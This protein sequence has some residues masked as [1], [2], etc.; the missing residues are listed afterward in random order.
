MRKIVLFLVISISFFKGFGQDY[1]NKGKDFWFCYPSHQAGTGSRLAIYLTSEVNASGTVSFGNNTIPFTVAANQTAIVRIGNATVPSN[2]TCY[3]SSNNFVEKNKAIHIQSDNP[4]AAYAHILNA[5]VSGST[6]L[7]PVPVLG[8]EYVVSSY[9]PQGT[10]ANTEKCEFDIV[11]VEDNTTVE[12]TPVNADISGAHPPFVPFQIVINK[13]DVYQYQS[14]GELSGTTVKSIASGTNVCQRI[15][16]IGATTRSAI[17]CNGASSG[18]NLF[19]QLTPKSS[20]GRRY[21]T[22]PFTLKNH[23]IIRIYASVPATPVIVNGVALPLVNIINNSYYEIT[24]STPQDISSD[25]PIAVF[26]YIITQNCDNV[27]SD[28]E[29]IFINPVEQTLKDITFVS[30]HNQLTPPN[31]NI[32]NHYL[33]LILKNSG[34]SISSLTVDGAPPAVTFTPI[35]ATGYSYATINLT[36]TTTLASPSHRVI[37]DSG[38]IA[39]AYGYGNVESYGYNAGTNVKDLTQQLELGTTYGTEN[40]PTLCIGENFQFKAYFPIPN[41]PTNNFDSLRWTCTSTALVP[42]NLPILE[43]GPLGP[44][45]DSTNIRNGKLVNWYSLPGLYSFNAPG[46]YTVTLTVYKSTN[47]G[48]GNEQD[49]D[50]TITVV[51]PPTPSFTYSAP[52]CYLEPVSFT[53]T[54]PQL[55]KPTYAWYWNFGDN[56]TSNQRNPTHTYAAAGTYTVKYVGITTTGCVSDT[57]TQ[58][59]TVPDVPNATISA[60]ATSACINAAVQPQVTF[61]ISGGTAPYLVD[62]SFNGTPQPTINTGLNIITI[63]VSTAVAGVFTYKL[64]S[65]K[66]QGSTLCK[67]VISNQSVT[68]TINPNVVMSYVNTSGAQNQTVC[69]NTPIS[70]IQYTLTT[71]GTGG[72][73]VFTSGTPAGITGSYNAGTQTYTIAGTPAVAGTYPFTV[74]PVATCTDPANVFNGVLT[75]SANATLSLQSASPDRT[76]CVN[77]AI[78]LP[79]DYLTGGGATGA[80]VTFTPALPGVTGTYNAA[81]HVFSISGTPSISGTFSYTVN[82]VSTCVNAPPLSGT[83]TVNA[84]AGINLTSLPATT[85]QTVCVNTPVAGIAYDIIGTV[86]SVTVTGLPAGVTYVYTPGVLPAN[87]SLTINGTPTVSNTIPYTY[88]ITVNGPC[89][90]PTPMNGTILVNPDAGIS[91]NAGSNANP[92]VC[93]NTPVSISYTVTGTV[94]SV[95]VTGTLPPGVTSVYTPG[96]GGGPG[97]LTISGTPTSSAGSPYNYT[98]KVTGPCQTP[99][100]Q[101]GAIT[102]T[103]DA[104]ISL[105]SPQNY[106]N[107][108]LCVNH[109]ILTTIWDIGGSATNAT[110][111]FTPPLPG[112]TGVYNAGT[113]QVT[114]SGTPTAVAST[115]VTYT[116]HV[117]TSGPCAAPD[118]IGSITVYPD[119]TLSIS[120]NGAQTVCIN[121]FITPIVYTWG[122]GA[123]GIVLPL[124][125]PPGL[126][127]TVDN[128]AQTVTITGAPSASGT[129][130]ITTV[131]NGC[132]PAQRSGQITVT[133]D[134][135]VGLVSAQST[136]NQTVCVNNPIVPITWTAGG[137]ATSVVVTGLPVGVVA[138][139]TGLSVTITGTPTTVSLNQQVFLYYVQAD[140][141]CRPIDSTGTII[142]NPD[143]V[144]TLTSGNPNQTVCV[145]TP[146]ST[147]SYHFDGGATGVTFTGPPGLTYTVGAGNTVTVQGSP[148]ASGTYTI[149]TTG[150]GCV[151]ASRT[152]TITVN[153]L[154][155]AGFNF[156]TPSCDTRVITFTD[157]STPNATSITGWVWDFGDGSPTATGN[158]VSHVYP[159]VGTYVAKLTVTNSNGCS[160]AVPFTRNVVITARPHSDFTVPSACISDNALFTDNS[161]G[162]TGVAADYKWDFGDPASGAANTQFAVNGTHTFSAA[163]TFTVTHIVF[164]AAGCTDTITH[165]ILISSSPV[166]N[167]SVANAAALC[168]NDSVSITDLSSIA[169]GAISKIEIYWDNAGAPG[170]FSAYNN[171]V[172]NTVYKHKYPNFQ[173]PLTQSYTIKLRVYTA[174]SCFTDKLVTITLNAVP[175]VQFNAMPDVCYDAAPFQIT[176]ASEIGGVPGNGVYSGPGV[177][178]TGIFSPAVAGVG[179]FTIKYTFTSSAAGC[180]D[181]MSNTIRVLDTA[182]AQFTYATPL[183]DGTAASFTELSTAPAGVT[184]NNT[185][186]NFGDGSPVQSHAPG[187]TFTHTY[188]TWGS[189]TVT[190]Y[191]TSAAGC[192]STTFTKQVVVNPVP[193]P[194]FSFKETSVCLPDAAVS[195]V[196]A[197][198]IANSTAM[199]YAWNFGDGSNISTAQTPPPHVYTGVGPYTVTLTAK[200]DSGCTKSVTNVVNFI[201][202]QPI[203][204]FNMSK[205]EV[206][207]G[208]DVIVTDKTDGLDGTVLQWHWGFGDGTFATTKQVQ[209]IYTTAQSYNIELYV[210]NSQGCTS[211]VAAQTFRVNPY[212]VISAGPDAIVLQGGSYTMQPTVS[213]STS[214]QYLWSP[215]TYL[216]STTDATPTAANIQADITYTLTVTGSGGCTAPSDQVF[217]KV[218]LAPK[219]PNTFTPNGDGI[220]ETWKIDYL[221]T[222]PNCKVQVFTR[223]GQLVFESR[224]YKTPWDGK[225]NG[226]ALPFDT[227]YYIIEPGN[228]RAPITGYVTIVK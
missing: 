31:T 111:T 129:W 21:L 18:D 71:G 128:I 162:G 26:Q 108:S 52:G 45:I 63:P 192:T 4:V 80:T 82:T 214:Y 79:I 55:P 116:Y 103:P 209:H 196:N 199:T 78:A 66:N 87:G 145:G 225:L 36:A 12:I 38:F 169:V 135:T 132:L 99:A 137:S 185:L 165:N 219:V 150:N 50:F 10:T 59:V 207:I 61:T 121:T 93:V 39:I 105:N 167:F 177:S 173:N 148:A 222:Y 23:D 115:P 228:G 2:A 120:G 189:Y 22:S 178:P 89:Q 134:G 174:G 95:V 74:S 187:S 90:V 153:P 210:I 175:K 109:A 104:T 139:V 98:V 20:W 176:Q 14:L 142:V 51:N 171:P 197:S 1:S 211:T 19:Q 11:G 190:M 100:D 181:S 202:P 186:W 172:V 86:T 81:T 83:I 194:A 88:T 159:A 221:D 73:L 200:S 163:G 35:G 44:P 17:G 154:P 208:G 130:T 114:I 13:G 43:T 149:T 191:N 220:N 15:V 195:V 227:Y 107:Q 69:I 28:P 3:I 7:L 48:C 60:S 136:K 97:T 179:T 92:T 166:A 37:N 101:L 58:Q 160:N 193:Q 123:T 70:D 54:T 25:D 62:Y 8:K 223:T 102:V 201:H 226:K 27:S 127:Y 94:S 125:L 117:S 180:V 147:V 164:S 42:N 57:V 85:N 155:A 91:L 205:P 184:L 198:S 152:G 41:T 47:E 216:T 126:T 24:A 76:V 53:E 157:N 168:V 161:T 133:P 206:C 40:T 143:H 224:G 151:T 146:I 65:V 213:G 46:T 140:G 75:V 131:G 124:T 49:Y 144:L 215:A 141:P 77:N 30:A 110:V 56:T 138:N 119:H 96:V 106:K 16:V 170:V 118:S 158:P 64:D 113:K 203:A 6:L 122:A 183:C 72:N 34:T 182:H 9:V 218:L 156:T 32:T 84:N 212:P 204:A 29:M 67:S 188:S 112:V 68:V 5:A 217:I 33:N